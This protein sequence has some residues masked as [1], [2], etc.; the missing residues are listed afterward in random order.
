MP[1]DVRVGS[2]V[3]ERLEELEEL[4][5]VLTTAVTLMITRVAP[6]FRTDIPSDVST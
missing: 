4:D 6:P 2:K 3:T 1:S 5:V